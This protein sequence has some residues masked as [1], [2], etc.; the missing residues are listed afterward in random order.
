M[1]ESPEPFRLS[2][3]LPAALILR[4][5]PGR[6]QPCLA[7]CRLDVDRVGLAVI[8]GP[9][10]ARVF[11]QAERFLQPHLRELPALAIAANLKFPGRIDGGKTDH[12]TIIV[13]ADIAFSP[14]PIEPYIP[15]AQALV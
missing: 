14:T 9:S 6:H 3:L 13:G 12:W 7:G 10:P 15:D 4:V 11:D 2:F 8:L 1:R 5:P